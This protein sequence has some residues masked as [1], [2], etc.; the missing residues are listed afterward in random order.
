MEFL[1]LVLIYVTAW[2]IWQRPEKESL[3]RTLL[4]VSILLMAFVFLVGTRTSLLPA[5]NY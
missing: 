4:C 5:V 1:N 3:A 2:L